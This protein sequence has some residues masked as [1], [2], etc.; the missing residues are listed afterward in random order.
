MI[1]F[2]QTSNNK[3]YKFLWL[4][5]NRFLKIKKSV[6]TS[7]FIIK[8][9]NSPKFCINNR[10]DIKKLDNKTHMVHVLKNVANFGLVY[11]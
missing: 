2:F 3:A 8:Y 7:A 9:N 1:H 11:K 5:V 6:N 10:F 4:Q